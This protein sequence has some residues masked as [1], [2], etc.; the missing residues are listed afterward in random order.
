[1][2][3]EFGSRGD[4]SSRRI[5]VIS[6]NRAGEEVRIC[7]SYLIVFVFSPYLGWKIKF[8][9]KVPMPMMEGTLTFEDVPAELVIPMMR[10]IHYY[11]EVDN[12]NEL[13]LDL[14]PLAEKYEIMSLRARCYMKA[15]KTLSVDN[16]V[17]TFLVVRECKSEDA[18]ILK[19][20]CLKMF[21]V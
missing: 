18:S 14:I 13:I 11:E 20:F 17:K 6:K 9:N 16:V 15:V 1:M 21:M 2:N 8:T 10:F 19:M 4:L 7:C 3:V 5:L 12:F